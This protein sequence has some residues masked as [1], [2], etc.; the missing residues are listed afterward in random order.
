[1]KVAFKKRLKFEGRF[2]WPSKKYV[3]KKI[4]REAHI[5]GL[6][7]KIK[8]YLSKVAKKPAKKAENKIETKGE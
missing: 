1:M 4:E 5:P 2:D 3:I 6:T 8:E 7:E